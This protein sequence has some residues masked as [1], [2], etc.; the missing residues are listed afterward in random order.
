MKTTIL[1]SNCPWTT[2]KNTTVLRKNI[3]GLS[4]GDWLV[5]VGIFSFNY[6]VDE[7]VGPLPA[8]HYPAGPTPW[9][10]SYH[11]AWVQAE[12]FL[13]GNE[14]KKQPRDFANELAGTH[15]E[16]DSYLPKI[17]KY[18]FLLLGRVLLPEIYEFWEKWPDSLEQPHRVCNTIQAFPTSR[19]PPF[20]FGLR[21]SLLEEEGFPFLA[22]LHLIQ[23][24][25]FAVRCLR[26]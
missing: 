12:A 19:C 24:Q 25:G 11:N 14:G 15:S 9:F 23:L 1:A 13:E 17:M 2:T 26:A 21:E 4:L 18:E 20:A 22:I 8:L 6:V 3:S 5:C 10:C 16:L 7:V